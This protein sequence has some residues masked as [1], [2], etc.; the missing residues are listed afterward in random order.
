[1]DKAAA[2]MSEKQSAAEIMLFTY[3]LNIYIS[4]IPKTKSCQYGYAHDLV[5][6]YCHKCWHMVKKTLISD[7]AELTDYPRTWRVGDSN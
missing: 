5:Q 1:M 3:A 2:L 7:M 4:D 6:C